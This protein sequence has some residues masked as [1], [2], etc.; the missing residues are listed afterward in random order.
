MFIGG[1]FDLMSGKVLCASTKELAEQLSK[2]I[3]QFSPPRDI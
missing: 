1:P 2:T 3:H